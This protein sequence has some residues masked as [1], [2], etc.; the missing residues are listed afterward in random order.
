MHGCQHLLNA[1]L[2]GGF[3]RIAVP[4]FGTDQLCAF[5][6]RQRHAKLLHKHRGGSFHRK[7]HVGHAL[8][9]GDGFAIFCK[10]A[11]RYMVPHAGGAQQGA[12]H[13]KN[14]VRGQFHGVPHNRFGVQNCTLQ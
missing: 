10:D 9:M 6:L 13:I 4:R 3:L 12:I 14:C 1:R 5:R 2:Y 7:G 8:F 11:V